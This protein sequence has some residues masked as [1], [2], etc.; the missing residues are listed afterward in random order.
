MIIKGY[1]NLK[2]IGKLSA[3]LQLYNKASTHIHNS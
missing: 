2:K 3:N 1:V